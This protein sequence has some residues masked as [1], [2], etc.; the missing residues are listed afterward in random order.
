M[1]DSGRG[2][3]RVDI[4]VR[5]STVAEQK[6]EMRMNLGLH[7]DLIADTK[8]FYDRFFRD[9]PK[10]DKERLSFRIRFLK[11]EMRE[12]ELAADLGDPEGVI[13]GCIDLM[14]VALGT[15]Y[16]MGV[17]IGEAWNIVHEANMKKQ[18][19][20][21]PSRFGSAGFDLT[22]PPGWISPSHKGNHKVDPL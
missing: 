7:P 12:T 13:D 16:E 5:E 6:R 21:N 9:L 8:E 17:N 20:P 15:L 11:E 19:N 14:V 3:E 18:R 4:E 22:K 2:S 10:F 1:S